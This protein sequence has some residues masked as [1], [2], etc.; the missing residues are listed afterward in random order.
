MPVQ[1]SY[2]GVY[3]Q[4]IPTSNPTVIGVT[5][6]STAFVD[7]FPSGP[8]GQAVQ[9]NSWNAFQQPC[10]GLDAR[11][12]ASYSILQYFLNGGQVAWVIRVVDPA[13]V[14]ASPPGVLS[15][16]VTLPTPPEQVLGGSTLSTSWSLG[17]G[18]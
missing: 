9:V 17:E 4:E 2:P 16:T 18:G 14:T 13:S 5:T 15:V 10:G 11:S 8:L 3:V 7:F 12:E 6:S 1:V